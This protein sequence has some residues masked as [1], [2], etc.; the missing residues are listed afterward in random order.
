MDSTKTATTTTTTTTTTTGAAGAAGDAGAAAGAA[1]PMDSEVRSLEYNQRELKAYKYA[2]EV[3]QGL[4]WDLQVE[5]DKLD[6]MRKNTSLRRHRAM[7]ELRIAYENKHGGAC[8]DK[9]EVEPDVGYDCVG[10]TTADS[11]AYMTPYWE[12]QDHLDKVEFMRKES[13][14]YFALKRQKAMEKLKLDFENK[15]R[16]A[17]KLKINIIHGESCNDW[18][19][20]GGDNDVGCDGKDEID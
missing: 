1:T 17:K 15:H 3:Y 19:C 8:S 4:Y 20:N 9:G 10:G 14:Y 11:S 12:L 16:E 13:I 6:T 7:E 18:D 5:L 2:L